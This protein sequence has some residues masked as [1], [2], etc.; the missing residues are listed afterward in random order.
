MTAYSAGG[1]V[2]FSS[3][4]P[5]TYTLTEEYPAAGYSAP[6]TNSYTVTV[7][8][9][10]NYSASFSIAGVTEN[11]ISNDP[12][13]STKLIKADSISKKPLDGAVF[14]V[15]APATLNDRYAALEQSYIKRG[16]AADFKWAFDG[17][18]WKQTVTG[19]S[20]KGEYAMVQLIPGSGYTLTETTAPKGYAAIGDKTFSVTGGKV[21]FDDN[22]ELEYLVLN[23]ATHEYDAVSS[24]NAD[25]IRVN[26]EPTFEDTKSIDKSWV[27][28][29]TVDPSDPKFPTVHLKNEK[30][31][32]K[33]TIVTIDKTK[34]RS[35]FTS[36]N[37]TRHMGCKRL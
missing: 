34:L 21:V 19:G 29:I 15:T 12:L 37:W 2:T 14:T 26:D 20:I 25:Y 6:V 31:E 13:A 30:S 32:E 23:T 11:T 18:N 22:D 10:G 27:G 9:T 35:F 33:I 36:S 3:V 7:T 5:G 8:K 24:E 17:T 16:E 28:E 1:T 4:E